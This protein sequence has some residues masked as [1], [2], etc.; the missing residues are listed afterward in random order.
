MTSETPIVI[1]DES[2]LTLQ[3]D[4]E[5][6]FGQHTST[7]VG[8]PSAASITLLRFSASPRSPISHQARSILIRVPDGVN[9]TDRSAEVSK[10]TIA[11]FTALLREK[12]KSG[13]NVNVLDVEEDDGVD[14]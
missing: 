3:D 6:N 8:G 1:Y 13:G 12:R 7:R 10:K 4:L 5:A 2:E 14:D 11:L 9:V